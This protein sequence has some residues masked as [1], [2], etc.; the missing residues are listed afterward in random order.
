MDSARFTFLFYR[1]INN[2]CTESE[3]AEFYK[4]IAA[5]D[6][7]AQLK[8]LMNDVWEKKEIHPAISWTK[9]DELFQKIIEGSG[10]VIPIARK[11]VFSKWINVAAAVVVLAI[12]LGA[13]GY[14][15]LHQ[16]PDQSL[17]QQTEL[18]SIHQI[19]KL[20]DGT[21]V[22]LNAGSSL[23]YPKSFDGKTSREV[24]LRGEGYFDVRHDSSKEFIVH[25]GEI[26]TVVLGTAFNIKA[27]EKEQQVVVTVTR[28]KVKVS[29]ADR[30]LGIITP[31]QQITFSR[32][33]SE[34][35]VRQVDSQQAITWADNDLF[36]DDTTF[37]EA[38]GELERRF[39]VTISLSNEK[40][41]TCRFTA[42]FLRGE[43][44]E[45]MLTVICEF[46]G[47]RFINP[48]AGKFKISGEG[49]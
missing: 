28:G 35:N 25:T 29:E 24:F 22:K 10:S 36:F 23:D 42:T 2:T 21:V 13:A 47:A 17:A 4:L 7:D 43:S 9:S 5:K 44:L 15:F 32:A 11:P 34:S 16:G 20:P 27:Y 19:I 18:P 6:Y 45:Q 26:T 3:K 40:L 8:S 46:N 48:E 38:I 30:V 33:D 39:G 12:S 49:C 31:N 1:Y 14:Y 41:R 37:E